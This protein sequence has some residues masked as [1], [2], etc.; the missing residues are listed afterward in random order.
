[1]IS[2][3]NINK[4]V[5]SLQRT[6]RQGQGTRGWLVTDACRNA[7]WGLWW[8]GRVRGPSTSRTDSLCESVRYA[9]DDRTAIRAYT[10][11]AITDR[12][13]YTIT[14]PGPRTLNGS[15]ILTRPSVGRS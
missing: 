11:F 15:S 8:R 4:Q 9:Q 13:A 1:M 2:F 12:C 14:H 10:A 6:E 5:L 3:A 7:L